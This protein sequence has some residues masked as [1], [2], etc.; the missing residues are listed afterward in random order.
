MKCILFVTTALFF[1]QEPVSDKEDIYNA[2]VKS[3][4]EWKYYDKNM[5]GAGE[6]QVSY[7]TYVFSS[8]GTLKRINTLNEIVGSHKWELI[9]ENNKLYLI[10][11]N[12]PNHIPRYKNYYPNDAKFQVLARKEHG[13][14]YLKLR[15]Q[16]EDKDNLSKEFEF[17]HKP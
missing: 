11:K 12:H 3:N 14:I 1:L 4:A 5:V 2:L 6:N 15:V 10:I 13:F 16:A 9:Q 7:T 8:N 17:R